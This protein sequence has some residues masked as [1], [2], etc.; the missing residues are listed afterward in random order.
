MERTPERAWRKPFGA[1]VLGFW[2]YQMSP[3]TNPVNSQAE[4]TQA[5]RLSDAEIT[6]LQETA[7]RLQYA[8]DATLDGMWDWDI[9]TGDVHFSPQWARLLG[10]EPE[11]IPQRVEFFFTVLHPDDVEPV[12][13]SIED[14]FA[15]RIA[16]K[17]HEVQLRTKAGVYRWFLDRGK[18]VERAA[19]GTPLRMVGTI[20]DITHRTRVEADL[21]AA[22]Q[23][24]EEAQAVA[25]TGNWSFDLATGEAKWSKYLFTLHGRSPEDGVLAVGEVADR[26]EP[27]DAERLQRA[28]ARTREEGTPY[29]LILRT[30][31]F[32]ADVWWVRSEGRARRDATGAIVGLFGTTT[33]VT[34]EVEREEA[35]RVA[36]N[37]AD[38]ASRA[39]SEFL[40]NM[41]HEIRTPLTAILGFAELLRDDPTVA[42]DA[43]GRTQT[44]DMIRDAGQHL[45][46]VLNDVLDLSKIEAA[47]MTVESIETPLV[48]I[49]NEVERLTRP[50]SMRKGVA[51]A[52]V[53]ATPLPDRVR[54]D[55]TRLRQMLLNLVGNAVKFTD[56]GQVTII[57]RCDERPA[58]SELI[59]DVAD[60]G[61]GMSDEQAASLFQPFEQVDRSV[62]RRHGGSGLGLVITRRLAAL[63]SGSVTLAETKVGAGS[64]FRL[65]IPIEVLPD[66]TF[67]PSPE[68]ASLFETQLPPARAAQ[69]AVTLSARVLVAEDLLDNQ[70]LIQIHLANAGAVVAC[71]LNGRIALAMLEEARASGQPFDLLV[72][73][74][75]MPEMDGYTLVETLRSRGD[76]IPIVALTARASAE[77]ARE[78]LAIGC[79]AVSVKPL[80]SSQFLATCARCVDERAAICTIPPE[81]HRGSEDRILH[82][83]TRLTTEDTE[84]TD[85]AQRAKKACC[86]VVSGHPA[87]IPAS[88]QA[89]IPASIQASIPA[90]IPASIHGRSQTSPD[91]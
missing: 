41:S 65:S 15:G 16:V 72:T 55:P 30:R 57:A 77:D 40:A 89:S 19:D 28:I 53:F 85:G 88:I 13:R 24:L 82:N 71:A 74:L 18:V 84:S 10:Y 69:P 67:V 47:R 14:H 22:T 49:L 2:R 54:S 11:E 58:G 73:D 1:V 7:E 6:R 79:D 29:T 48:S 25:R 21:V 64:R 42:A 12:R 9:A 63:M 33:D 61:P 91:Q 38:A 59:I 4:T 17:Q 76:D 44:V 32:N 75:H 68:S 37:Q 87:S 78:C 70:K 20:T 80:D 83:S 39:K 60:T 23:L 36:R 5:S 90:S 62:T 8:A 50:A 27:Q 43:E 52:M 31:G 51:V 56:V 66:A 45:L 86:E 35:L 3:L 46:T 34:A 81:N 26:F